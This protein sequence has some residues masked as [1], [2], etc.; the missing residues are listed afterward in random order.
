MRINKACAAFL[1]ISVILT[2]KSIFAQADELRQVKGLRDDIQIIN[3]L[4][5]L[6]LRPKQVEFILQKAREAKAIRDAAEVKVNSHKSEMTGAIL[7]IKEEVGDGKVTIEQEN[8]QTFHRLTEEIEGL[9]KQSYRKQ[10]NIAGEVEDNLEEFQLL[11]LD[12]YK[13]CIIPIISDGRIGQVDGSNGISKALERVRDI[14]QVRYEQI[15]DEL[16]ERII[17]KA[18]SKLPPRVELD[19]AQT[20]AMIFEAFEKARSMQDAEFSVQKDNIAAGLENRIL[21][22]KPHMERS[23][24]IIQFLLTDNAIPILEERLSRSG[25]KK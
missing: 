20:R 23:D 14:P 15:K 3:L 5:N 24:K 1:A 12:S 25:N 18:K 6:S 16:A 2:A 13:P 19:E 21:P 10:E 4:N 9:M 17:E 11:A 7:A 22:E 8:A